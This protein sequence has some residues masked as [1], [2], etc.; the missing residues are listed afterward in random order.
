MPWRSRRSEEQCNAVLRRICGTTGVA[1]TH[2]WTV[3]HHYGFHPCHLHTVQRLPGDHANRVRHCE[4]PQPPPQI[5]FTDE[6]PT[7]NTRNSHFWGQQ[8]P[9]QVTQCHIHQRYSVNM[10]CIASGNYLTGPRV[11][12]GRTT[13]PYYRNFMENGRL[14]YSE[15]ASLAIRGRQ[16][17]QYGSATPHVGGKVKEFLNEKFERRWIG[18]KWAGGLARSVTR[19][20]PIRFLPVGLHEIESISQR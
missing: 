12:E 3:V 8:N 11:I 18:N 9:H 4:W 17:L 2:V 5:L 6:A 19:I 16:C 20:E 14:R 13:A 10:W 1:Q 7:S 15:Y